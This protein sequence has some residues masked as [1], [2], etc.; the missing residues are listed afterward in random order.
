MPEPQP[1]PGLRQFGSRE[2]ASE[3]AATFAGAALERAIAL[4]GTASFMVSGG[5]TP[6]G[7]FA[8]MATLTLN[9]PSVTV[10]LVDERWV[11]PDDQG[12]NERLVRQ[13][14]MTQQ[15]ADAKFL[16]MRTLATSA[17][18]AAPERSRAYASHCAPISCLMLGM[19]TDGHT[20]SWFPGSPSLADALT[21][22][23][24]AVVVAVD[25]AGC[26][27]AGAFP[28]R[29]TLTGPVIVSA[30]SALLLIFGAEKRDIFHR[31]MD[32]PAAKYP[33]RH[34]LDGLGE[35]LEIFW[36]P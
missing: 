31:A 28:S 33:I 6:V 12:S 19:G 36:A 10:G 9:W 20:A 23:G 30:E 25:A 18:M 11:P 17:E 2:D 13:S 24:G 26:A 16:P 29:L 35:R 34:A 22:P 7:M 1:G 15:A 4:K 27:G 8:R 32:A 3:A 21:P 5:S 14:L